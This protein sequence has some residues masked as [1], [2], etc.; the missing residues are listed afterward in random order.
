MKVNTQINYNSKPNDNS[1]YS[2]KG[3]D[4]IM[5]SKITKEYSMT[6]S[7]IICDI[8]KLFIDLFYA[9]MQFFFI[10]IKR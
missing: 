9:F 3:I 7:R 4:T 5:C 10:Y 8:D 2:N 6:L 1:N